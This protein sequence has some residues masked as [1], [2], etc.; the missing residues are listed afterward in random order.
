VDLADPAYSFSAWCS[1]PLSA[2]PARNQVRVSVSTLSPEE[3]AQLQQIGLG[4]H[5][6]TRRHAEA[7]AADVD[8]R[9][10]FVLVPLFAGPTLL[11][12]AGGRELPAS[13]RY[14]ALHVHAAWFAAGVLGE[15]ADR[16]AGRFCG[17]GGDGDARVPDGVS[18]VSLRR[19]Y[20]SSMRKTL[21]A[22]IRAQPT[23]SRAAASVVAIVF[24]VIRRFMEIDL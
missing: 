8:S 2:S 3:R 5:G 22:T 14:F 21:A 12:S 15:V 19:T 16:E 20:R 18:F 7:S 4:Q 10:M 6:R 11:A 13:L 23:A 1:S 24:P 17:L 9:A